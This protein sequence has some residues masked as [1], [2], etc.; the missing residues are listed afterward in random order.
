MNKFEHLFASHICHNGYHNGCRMRSR[1][2]HTLLGVCDVRLAID[3]IL[4]LCRTY[5]VIMPLYYGFVECEFVCLLS[6]F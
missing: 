4:Y 5:F 2:S 3:L 6:L 1:R